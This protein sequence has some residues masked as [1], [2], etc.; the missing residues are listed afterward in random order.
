MV[1]GPQGDQLE[2]RPPPER[3]AC[4]TMRRWM[5][6]GFLTDLETKPE[7]LGRLADALDRDDPW[8]DVPATTRRLLFIGMGSSHYAGSVA[9]ARLRSHGI[10]AVAEL[11]S[12]DLLPPPRPETVVVAVSAGGGSRETVQAASQ[13][14]D[15]CPVVLLTNDAGSALAQTVHVRRTDAGRCGG[16][17]RGLPDLPAHARTTARPRAAA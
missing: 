16:R 2:S 1:D 15:R 10:D 9:A 13:Y 5:L 7:A 8:A 11:S 12:S 3:T 4:G 17:G 6:Q 14:V